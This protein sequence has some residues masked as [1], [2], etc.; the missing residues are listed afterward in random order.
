MYKGLGSD[1]SRLQRLSSEI[2]K[3]LGGSAARR[4]N[5]ARM[6]QLKRLEDA[7]TAY[8]AQGTPIPGDIGQVN[9]E[10]EVSFDS[11]ATETPEV[12]ATPEAEE[13]SATP[14]A[15][16]AA[17]S[18]MTRLFGPI[19][20]ILS[21]LSLVLW[22]LE[23]RVLRSHISE[24]R[25]SSSRHRTELDSMKG[26]GRPG[27]EAPSELTFSQRKQVEELVER[28]V[29]QRLAELTPQG[30]T[31]AEAAPAMPTV[32]PVPAAA[33]PVAPPPAAVAPPAFHESGAPTVPSGTAAAA[34]PVT[35]PL[36]A[37]FS[38]SA[39][40]TS[41]R[42][43]TPPVAE[44]P[45]PSAVTTAAP[46]SA[47]PAPEFASVVPP[48]PPRGEVPETPHPEPQPLGYF[49]AEMPVDGGFPEE[50]LTT[51]ARPDSIYE[52]TPDPLQPDV[53]SFRLNDDPQVQ[54]Y[55][56]QS[57]TDVLSEACRYQVPGGPATRIVTEAPGLLRKDGSVWQIEQLARIRFE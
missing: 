27:Q 53:A 8:V 7:L 25:S 42:S 57:T 40:P 31:A 47:A 51:L 19:A 28:L 50:A 45:A 35:P 9:A 44:V 4:K 5:P 23:R 49:Y 13:T 12:V 11:T 6:A 17:E 10:S 54:E 24:L 15:A 26:A 37:S 20:L 33:P 22:W 39:P 56:L 18:P 48:V 21:L 34:P 52:I 29:Q 1:A 3:K 2:V 43:T 46:T 30:R 38:D 14:A 36:P 55:I 41:S 32:A 16:S